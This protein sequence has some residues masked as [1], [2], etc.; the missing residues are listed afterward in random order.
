MGLFLQASDADYTRIPEDR[1]TT[2]TR[3]LEETWFLY[4]HPEQ[5]EEPK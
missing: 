1:Q 2:E 5:S 3:F 4:G